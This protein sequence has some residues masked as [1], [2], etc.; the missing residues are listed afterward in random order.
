MGRVMQMYSVSNSATLVFSGYLNGECD[1]GF[2][3]NKDDHRINLISIAT[4]LF[5][6]RDL[7]T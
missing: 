4:R 2:D 1:S 7:N 3:M 6:E 5:A